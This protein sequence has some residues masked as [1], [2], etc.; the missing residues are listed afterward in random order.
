MRFSALL[1]ASVAAVLVFSAPAFAAIEGAPICIGCL[2]VTGM[3]QQIAMVKSTTATVALKG[4]CN[5]L[6]GGSITTVCDTLGGVLGPLLDLDL[7]L[8]RSPEW[9]CG[10]T[11]KLCKGATAKC[12]LFDSWPP[13]RIPKEAYQSP[14][15]RSIFESAQ[16]ADSPDVAM[17]RA[18]FASPNPALDAIEYFMAKYAEILRYAPASEDSRTPAEVLSN[19]AEY[20]K[21]SSAPQLFRTEA[22][23]LAAAAAALASPLGGEHFPIVDKD[24]DR[25]SIVPKIRG[26]DWA[27]RDCNDW[28]PTVYPGRRDATGKANSVDHN[29]NGIFGT[30][31]ASGKSYEEELCSGTPQYGLVSV[32]DS[33]TAHFSIPP[34]WLDPTQAS[35]QAYETLISVISNEADW[36]QCS[37]ST[38]WTARENCPR[39]HK[40]AT[41]TSMYQRVRAAN[42]CSHRDYHNLGVNGG[43]SRNMG[44][45]PGILDSFIRNAQ[46]DHPAIVMYSVIG[47][48]VC[49]RDPTVMTT[50]EAFRANTRKALQ[51]LDSKLAPGSQV[52]LGGLVDGRILYNTMA[53]RT[54]PAGMKYSTF[55]DF[56]NCLET[57]PCSGW[58]NSDENIRNA[59]TA[60]AAELSAVYP[61]IIGKENFANFKAI[62]IPVMDVFGRIAAEW[63]DSG[64]SIVD[65]IELTDGFHP[66]TTAQSLLADAM[67]NYAVSQGLEVP[68]NPNNARIE[69]LFGNQGG[70]I[71]N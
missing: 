56:L 37:L 25:H 27:G 46:S 36:P 3:T 31:K 14:R 54:H 10:K 20:A 8:K 53:D 19:L 12:T 40:D 65:L 29:C 28:D 33:A 6:T 15:A 26:Y 2:I 44:P 7:A 13:V 66:S 48:D 23:A 60:R 68:V 62:Y 71:E 1:L 5:D 59:T 55:Y 11:V 41:Y 39:I 50:V 64:H 21:L 35:A 45:S 30:N 42:R 34:S 67:W 9:T 49:N 63:R 32:G 24:K 16:P 69:E 38:G 47:N 17:A 58:M 61:E 70:Y 52:L 22:A 18:I 43:S 57:S 51:L 4:W